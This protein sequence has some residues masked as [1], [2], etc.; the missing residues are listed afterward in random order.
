VAVV[1]ATTLYSVSFFQIWYAREARFYAQLTFFSLGCIYCAVLCLE[2]LSV[3]RLFLLALFLSASLYTHNLAWFYLPGLVVFWFTYPSEMTARARIKGGLIGAG[4]TLLLFL[5]WL[6]SFIAQARFVRQ[7]GFWA[8]RPGPR[9]LLDSLCILDG[10]DTRSFQ[11]LFRSHFHTSRL[12]GFWT[13]AP[14]FFCVFVFVVAF[15]FHAVQQVNRRK[16]A[17][18]L[19]YSVLPIL[20]VAFESR[21]LTPVFIN[22]AFLGSSALLPI[23]LCLPIAY[24]ASTRLEDATV[25][26][27][28]HCQSVQ[29]LEFHWIELRRCFVRNSTN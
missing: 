19:A 28:S 18:M 1:L 22:R 9:D 27:T 5:P 23:V 3:L 29:V 16:A 20:L 13:W 2:R 26:L 14:A 21:F 15:A 24:Q 7:G 6:P 12:F 11:D 10:F 8:P 4:E 17:A 25:Y